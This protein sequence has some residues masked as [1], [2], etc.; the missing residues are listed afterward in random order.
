MPITIENTQTNVLSAHSVQDIDAN[1]QLVGG[2]ANLG[3]IVA[4]KNGAK[5]YFTWCSGA[6]RIKEE[7]KVWFE[8]ETEAK[9]AGYA[10][11]SN[12]KGLK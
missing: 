7:N 4:S 3:S 11:A 6:T 10:P 1:P 9:N 2:A 5:Y 12:C 8:S